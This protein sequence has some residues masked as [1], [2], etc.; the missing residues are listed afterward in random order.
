MV[1]TAIQAFTRSSVAYSFSVQI[2]E[3]GYGFELREADIAYQIVKT[4]A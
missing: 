2:A 4:C 1:G 3:T